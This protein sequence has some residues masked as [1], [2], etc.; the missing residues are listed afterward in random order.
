MATIGK[1]KISTVASLAAGGTHV[2]RWNN[3]PE[4]SPLGYTAVP[5]PPAASGQHGTSQGSVEVVRVQL[6]Y[7]RDNYNG[8]KRHV[9]I[10]VKNTG[11]T[12]TGFD[13]WESWVSS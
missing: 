4:N 2:V 11:T 9:D 3:Y 7:Q 13:V 1:Q 10:H 8:D 12:T 6:T 5:V